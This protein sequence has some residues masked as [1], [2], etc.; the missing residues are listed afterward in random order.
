MSKFIT[1][2]NSSDDMKYDDVY[3]NQ[4]V[5]DQK[6]R[7]KLVQDVTEDDEKPSVKVTAECIEGPH[8]GKV[9]TQKYYFHAKARW[10][11]RKMHLACGL[12]NTVK[13]ET[14]TEKHVRAD[15]IPEMWL[16]KIIVANV[17]ME[18]S[19]DMSAEYTSITQER[20]LQK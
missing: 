3:Y 2:F 13:T 7:I 18:M 12:Y 4:T 16:G 17:V 9:A 19:Q 6:L 10:R 20:E 14:G 8:I 5:Q 11:A 1:D 15:A